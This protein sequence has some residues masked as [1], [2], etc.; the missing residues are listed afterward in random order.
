M[1]NGMNWV[2]EAE[3][4]KAGAII[5]E[6]LQFFQGARQSAQERAERYMQEDEARFVRKP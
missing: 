2:Q 4:R 6:R 3:T 1:T 5:S